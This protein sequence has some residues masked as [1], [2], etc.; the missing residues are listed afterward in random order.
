MFPYLFCIAFAA[1]QSQEPPIQGHIYDLNFQGIAGVEVMLSGDTTIT[2]TTDTTGFYFFDILPGTYTIT[3]IKREPKLNRGL[4]SIDAAKITQYILTGQ[5]WQWSPRHWLSCDITGDYA[6]TTEDAAA[7]LS[8]WQGTPY[9]LQYIQ[10]FNG[11]NWWRFVPLS[12]DAA[13]FGQMELPNYPQARTVAV[14]DDIETIS[15]TGFIRG[16]VDGSAI[17]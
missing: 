17:E 2:K 8:A 13:W 14:L 3:P 10:Q 7:V 9:S 12:W 5:N 1:C 6:I 4:D 15:F 11:I 16:D